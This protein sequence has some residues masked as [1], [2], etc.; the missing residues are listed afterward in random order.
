[1]KIEFYHVDAFEVANYEPIWRTL[2]Q[3]GIDAT[4]VAVPGNNNSSEA[5]WFDFDRFT[6]YCTARG[7][8]FNTAPDPDAHVAVTTQNADILRDYNYRVRLMYGPVVYPE[9]WALQ[10]HSVKPFDAVLVHGKAYLDQYAQWLPRER[11]HIIGYPRYDEFFSGRLRKDVI[12]QYWDIHDQKPILAFLPTWGDNTAFDAFFPTL[13]SLADK[14]HIIVR[15]HH[16]TLRFERNRMLAMRSSGLLMLDNA[17]DLEQIYAGAD[18]VLAD[19]RSGSLFEA[20]MC[21]IPTVGMVVDPTEISGW[22]SHNGVDK[23][24]V[25]CSDPSLLVKAIESALQQSHHADHCTQWAD[26]HVAFRDGSS[27]K[28]AAETLIELAM[29]QLTK[30]KN[31]ASKTQPSNSLLTPVYKT[32]LENN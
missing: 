24:S 13:L 10:Q 26:N 18:V 20:C 27:A 31:S 16:C 2:R 17:F 30:N 19:V 3:M 4:M 25:L 32:N 9:A 11:L 8:P 7:I 15:P 29:H 22:L 12:R 14:Y 23:M 28:H 6:A 5:G 1:M 21:K